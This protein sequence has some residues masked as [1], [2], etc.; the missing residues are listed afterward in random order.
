MPEGQERSNLEVGAERVQF[1][2]DGRGR[3]M[4]PGTDPDADPHATDDVPF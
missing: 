1:L 3:R 2:S 4:T